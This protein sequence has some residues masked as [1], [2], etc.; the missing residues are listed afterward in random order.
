[1]R[2]EKQ[3]NEQKSKFEDITTKIKRQD[4]ALIESARAS[5]L[6]LTNNE[7]NNKKYVVR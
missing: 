3:I 4:L 7:T 1:M 6:S 5:R 2:F